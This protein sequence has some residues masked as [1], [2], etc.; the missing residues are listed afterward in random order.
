MK[1][2]KLT[3]WFPAD[4][5]PVHVGIYQTDAVYGRINYQYWTGKH[6]GLQGFADDFWPYL[7]GLAK[8]KSN[9][10]NVKWR[11][12]ANPPKE[13]KQKGEK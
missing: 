7:N 8:H 13:T 1:K 12:L 2:P 11:G 9:F 10:Q 5:K 3:P 6:W 4:V